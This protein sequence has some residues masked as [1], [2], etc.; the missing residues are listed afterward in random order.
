MVTHTVSLAER[1]RGP[2]LRG[3]P[4]HHP[5]TGDVLR[6]KTSDNLSHTGWKP[7]PEWL[8][9]FRVDAP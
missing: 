4:D 7:W 3:F 1:T 6:A 2:D 9:E 5:S 8:S